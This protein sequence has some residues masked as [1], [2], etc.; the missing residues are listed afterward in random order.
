MKK[1]AAFSLALVLSA[2]LS[3]TAFAADDVRSVTVETHIAPNYIV[4]I[5]ASTT[6]DFNKVDTDFGE[7]KLTAAQ[8][9]PGK[10]VKVALSASGTLKNSK[11]NN[12]T[13]AYQI[14]NGD[15][16]F[17]SATYEKVGDSTALTIHIAKADWNAAYAGDYADTVTF[18]ISYE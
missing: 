15:T 18:T 14:L 7:I 11:D 1:M 6:V 17:K 8:L 3:T 10:K 5:P 2:A 4:T 13:L 16:A 12:K 9:D